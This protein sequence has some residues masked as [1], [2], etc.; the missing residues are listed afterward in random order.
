M[1]IQVI[2]GSTRPGRES[3]RVAKWV[4]QTAVTNAK[5]EAE[6]V[7]L[8]DYDLPLFNEAVSP[9]YNPKRELGD[10]AGA[11]LG[12]LAEADGYIFISP[13]YNHSVTGVLKNALDYVDFQL[14][15]KPAAIVSYGTVGGARGAEHLKA[16]LI[17][18]KAAIVPEAVALTRRVTEILDENGKLSDAAAAVPY[19]PA[20]ALQTTLD[21]LEWWTE[22]LLAG[23]AAIVK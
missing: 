23:R 21:E 22:T 13:E 2:I 15:K 18:S 10:A 8:A 20:K 17:E 5:F 12:K 9:R 1:K 6:T 16:I 14:A 3:L 19:G 7:D 11:W 4:A